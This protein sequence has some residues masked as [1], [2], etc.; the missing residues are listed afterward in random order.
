MQQF[1]SILSSGNITS[2][3]SQCVLLVSRNAVTKNHGS[4]RLLYSFSIAFSDDGDAELLKTLV[5]LSVGS[6]TVPDSGVL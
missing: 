5:E 3:Q 6:T 4:L 1:L 2:R